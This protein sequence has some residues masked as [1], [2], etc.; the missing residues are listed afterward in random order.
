MSYARDTEIMIEAMQAF[1]NGRPIEFRRG[2]A[3]NWE[4]CPA[5]VWDWMNFVYRAKPTE[6]LTPDFINW[7]AVNERYK[8]M[9]RDADGV[10]YLHATHPTINRIP[11]MGYWIGDEG[12][13]DARLF[14]SYK[15]G[16]VDWEDSLVKRL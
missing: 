3:K 6:E 10:P 5:P 7:S 13:I 11:T 2:G 8:F 4:P 12:S 15:Q 16:T 9:T 1:V 14:A